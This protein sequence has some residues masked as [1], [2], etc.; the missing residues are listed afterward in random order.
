MECF[1]QG[2]YE[3]T[4]IGEM[5]PVYLDRAE[6]T[7]APGPVRF[8]LEREG[9]LQAWARLRENESDERA[10]LQEMPLFQV[11]NVAREIKPGASIIATTTDERGKQYPAL[12]TQRFGR[13]RT[14][15]CTVG[16]L[17]RWGMLNQETHRDLDKC[18]RQLVRWLVADTP[19]QV[20][21][22]A[23]P[24]EAGQA[25]NL[26][27]RARDARFQ[28][29]D[30]A[31]VSVEVQ[32]LPTAM[33]NS[34]PAPLRLRADPSLKEPGLYEAVYVPRGTGGY[35]ARAIATNSVGIEVGRAEAGWATDLAADEFRS[36]QPNFA[37]LQEIARRTGGELTSPTQLEQFARRLPARK[38][39][40]MEDSTSPA[41]H[42]P[43]M[44]AFSLACFVGEWGLRRWKGMP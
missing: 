7:V 37:L 30:D 18:W 23:E 5:L 1:Q 11:L 8:N 12:A 16:D 35:L 33:T 24:A 38:A 44:L 14:A 19:R 25:V 34:A 15:A 39:P 17:W 31:A 32:P 10:R 36:L 28:P 43:A 22:T 21:L 9:W 42:T 29:L 3:R 26:Q 13:G 4:P 6:H 41:W 27:V 2:K 20:E 40:L